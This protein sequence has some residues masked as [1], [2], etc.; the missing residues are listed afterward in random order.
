[1]FSRGCKSLKPRLN[2]SSLDVCA[3]QPH[4]VRMMTPNTKI[5]SL[6]I[7]LAACCGLTLGQENPSALLQIEFE[8]NVQYN[9]D[10]SDVSKLATDPGV[11]TAAGAKN[12]MS[13]VVIA[14][15]VAVNGQ[16]A[17]GVF[18]RERRMIS[19]NPSAGPGQ[20]IADVTRT[21]SG[22]QT[23]F[24]IL[25]ADGTPVGSIFLAGFGGGSPAPPGAP[26]I[27]GASNLAIVGGTGAF[28]GARGQGGE[29]PVTGGSTARQASMSEDPSNRRRNGGGK[30]R[31]V[32]HLI[33]MEAPL[34]LNS[35]EIRIPELGFPLNGPAVFHS[36]FSQVTTAKPAHA[37]EILISLAKG[38]GPTRPGVD[39]GQPFPTWPANPLQQINS[40]VNVT[41]NGQSADIINAIGWPGLVSEYRVDFRVPNG[42]ASGLMAVQLSAAWIQGPAVSIPIQ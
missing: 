38:M 40:P 30:M 7:V 13:N 42:T 17:K 39:P 4:C 14:D 8:N 1:M 27:Q 16:P 41:V 9:Q 18:V 20:A 35:G 34:I 3:R 10:V 5:I 31:W 26:L 15:I 22:F 11:T 6:T 2:P 23:A 28:L 36:D 33:P 19:L 25:Q 12:F 37:G 21:F 29:A 24:E 32:L